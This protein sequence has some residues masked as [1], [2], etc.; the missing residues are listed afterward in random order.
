MTKQSK[1]MVT[2]RVQKTIAFENF[3]DDYVGQLNEMIGQL[4]NL[5]YAVDVES[6]DDV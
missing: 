1:I 5:G 4:N 3:E 6:E 2:M